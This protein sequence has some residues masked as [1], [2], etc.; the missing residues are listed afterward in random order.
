MTRYHE[1]A[2]RGAILL[3][4]TLATV[5]LYFLARSNV[6]SYATGVFW[7]GTITGFAAF[8]FLSSLTMTIFL[9]RKRGLLT[10]KQGLVLSTLILSA[11]VT[12]ITYYFKPGD[13]D[14]WWY[15][16]I[17]GFLIC[18]ILAFLTGTVYLAFKLMHK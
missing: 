15:G 3:L 9:V 1:Y 4:S 12:A 13:S 10:K 16:T 6:L 7:D 18:V 8:L 14:V 5:I 11:L 17:T 2:V